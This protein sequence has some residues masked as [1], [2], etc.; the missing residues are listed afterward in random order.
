MDRAALAAF[1]PLGVAAGAWWWPRRWRHVEVD[2][3]CG[4]LAPG[5]AQLLGVIVGASVT[6]HLGV[7]DARL[8]MFILSNGATISGHLQSSN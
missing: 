6:R 2:R 8:V 7:P 4:A 5:R 1:L 3:P